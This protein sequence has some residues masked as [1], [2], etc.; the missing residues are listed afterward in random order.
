MERLVAVKMIRSGEL[1][2]D[3][4]VKRFYVEAQAAGTLD[5]PNIVSVHEVGEAEGHHF[6]SMTFI[7]G[8]DLGKL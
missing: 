6:F 4:E 3:K 5:H 7:D 1:A 2:S 8:V